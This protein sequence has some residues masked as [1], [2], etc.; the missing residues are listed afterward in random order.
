MKKS[1]EEIIKNIQVPYDKNHQDRLKQNL[2]VKAKNLYAEK[3]QNTPFFQK[4]FSFFWKKGLAFL[5]LILFVSSILL[6]RHHM[7]QTEVANARVIVDQAIKN[8]SELDFDEKNMSGDLRATLELLQKA[9]ENK[10]LRYLGEEDLGDRKI[11][12]LAFNDA[13]IGSNIIIYLQ[14]KNTF[15]PAYQENYSHYVINL[16]LAGEGQSLRVEAGKID[17]QKLSKSLQDKDL[18]NDLLKT[19]IAKQNAATL[20]GIKQQLKEYGRWCDEGMGGDMSGP[21]LPSH[22]N[23]QELAD[24][25]EPVVK[26][27]EAFVGPIICQRDEKGKIKSFDLAFQTVSEL[28]KHR[29]DAL[30]LLDQTDQLL[31]SFDTQEARIKQKLIQRM[32]RASLVTTSLRDIFDHFTHDVKGN[33]NGVYKRVQAVYAS[34]CIVV[35]SKG[36]DCP[37]ITAFIDPEQKS[38]KGVLFDFSLSHG[39]EHTS[40]LKLE[41]KVI[42]NEI[43]EKQQL[44]KKLTVQSAQTEGIQYLVSYH[45]K[46]LLSY[47]FYSGYGIEKLATLLEPI[48]QQSNMLI[49]KIDWDRDLVHPGEEKN[50]PAFTITALPIEDLL[51]PK[52]EAK[53]YEKAQEI[54]RQTMQ[55]L[56]PTYGQFAQK[57]AMLKAAREAQDLQY[58]GEKKLENGKKVKE[59]TFTDSRTGVIRSV[60]IDPEDLTLNGIVF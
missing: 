36:K 33:R 35:D 56:H 17:P 34:D 58:V 14:P 50:I 53:Q 12:Q 55:S 30:T 25:L 51:F 3:A 7:V 46:E 27:S 44:V 1:F 11:Y 57:L 5:T 23:D 13:N 54:L 43:L 29:D 49:W 37:Q 60:Y 31:E 15:W 42:G 6:V 8:L 32:K 24:I 39:G 16:G 41:G 18:K 9:L 10:N 52:N 45:N 2:M 20:F 21:T 40:F 22:L 4:P 48:I 28:K 19:L 59:L 26:D 38:E 47:L